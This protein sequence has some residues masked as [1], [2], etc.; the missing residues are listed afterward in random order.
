[1]KNSE[2]FTLIELMA[3]VAILSILAVIALGAYT[4][5]VVR[6][7][8]SEGLAF[9]ADGTLY[10]ADDDTLTFFPLNP[11]NALVDVRTRSPIPARPRKV[12]A[13]APRATP[14]PPSIAPTNN[15]R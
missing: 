3:V 14:S 2:G 7:K 15:H 6:S 12:S 4:D 8:V 5:Y 1:M 10:A 11:D 13:S 9:A